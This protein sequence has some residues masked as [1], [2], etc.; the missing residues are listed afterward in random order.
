[1][2]IIRTDR[3]L[4]NP[5]QPRTVID[6]DE[7]EE[8]AASLREEG[9]LNA[10]A[11]ETLPDGWYMLLDGERRWRAAVMNGW[12]EIEA[13]VRPASADDAER[14]ILALV[15]NLQR[16]D[17]GP[18]DVA[19]GYATLRET[20][21]VAEIAR[22]MGRSAGH[23]YQFLGLLGGG[24]TEHS[25][26]ALNRKRIPLDFTMLRM[27]AELDA[28]SQTALVNRA[29]RQRSSGLSMRHM[30]S[31]FRG[32]ANFKAR[33]RLRLT[34]AMAEGMPPAQAVAG[35][36][37]VDGQGPALAETCRRCGMADDGLMAVCRDCPLVT[38]VLVWAD[39]HA[40]VA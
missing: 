11:V 35:I 24:L 30:I 39:L 8:L 2:A 26:D 14:L 16:E 31:G 29:I 23:V 27:L 4:T 10:I 33:R 40:V 20:M 7:L 18:V 38:F 13:T 25:L 5:A 12:P 22:R 9:L 21:P 28:E 19:R 34:T 37:N 32:G 17:M 6:Q 15:G 3:I 1:M 36:D